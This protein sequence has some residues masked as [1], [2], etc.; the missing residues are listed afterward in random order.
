MLNL[1]LFG[2]PGAGKGTQSKLLIEKY[3]LVY[4]STGDILRQE[5]SEKTD[6]GLQAK[7]IIDKGRLVSEDIIVQIIEKRIS[8]NPHV[9]GILFDG[10]PR[11]VVQAYILEGLL[12]RLN[13]SLDCM[14]SLEV[15]NEELLKRMLERAKTSGRSDDNEEVIRYRLQEYENKTLPVSEFYH[16]REKFYPI[17]GVGTIDDI[18]DRICTVID[19]TQQNELF[20]I[21]LSGPPGAGKGTQGQNL[22]R[23]FNL[24]YLSSGHLLREQVKEDTDLGRRAKEFI[25]KGDNVPDE[26][27]VQV[28]DRALKMHKNSRGFIF[29][30]FPRTIV[31]AYILDG[32]LRKFD[33]SVTYAIDI[34]V[35][36]LESVK[37]LLARAKTPRKRIYD[38]NPEIIIHRLEEYELK[39]E[40]VCDYYKKQNAYIAVDGMGSSEDVSARLLDTIHELVD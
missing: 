37:R 27:V 38:E 11:T 29:K 24:T 20:N 15:P 1:A 7:A 12:L 30:G 28:I 32:L 10:F 35:P 17:N 9:K 36:H 23:E 40:A 16:E 31:Q 22:A 33:S 8:M 18:F 19:K 13:T 6:L 39:S 25:D 2:P 5:I 14:I 4:I 21:V 3:N 34:R 26:I